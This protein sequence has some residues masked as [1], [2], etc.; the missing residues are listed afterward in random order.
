MYSLIILK[1]LHAC[2]FFFLNIYWRMV[3][4]QCC[5]RFCCTAEWIGHIAPLFW[6][7]FPGRLPQRWSGAP[8]AVR[9]VLLGYLLYTQYQQYPSTVGVIVNPNPPAHPTLPLTSLVQP[10]YSNFVWFPFLFPPQ[11]DLFCW[12]LNNLLVLMMR[13]TCLF[14]VLSVPVFLFID[15]LPSTLLSSKTFL[16]MNV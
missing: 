12:S 6:I 4:L 10:L 7:S 15:S 1:W 14:F 2:S 8:R 16:E 9:E 13:P 11:A 3:A 5:I